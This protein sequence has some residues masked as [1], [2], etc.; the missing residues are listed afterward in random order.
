M[1]QMSSQFQPKP[2]NDEDKAALK[3]QLSKSFHERD[4]AWI[5]DPRIHVERTRVAPSRID[6]DNRESWKAT[7]EPGL[8]REKRKMIKHGDDK[9]V[10][11]V[12]RPNHYDLFVMDGHH[13]AEAYTQLLG[14]PPEKQNKNVRALHGEMPA[15]E[16]HVPR[17]NGPW[18]TLHDKQEHNKNA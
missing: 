12:Q 3:E 9:P 2:G 11:L 16:I 1:P 14:K 13:H 15:F 5:D 6:W 18:D 10:A 7:H 8:V 4:L 17:T